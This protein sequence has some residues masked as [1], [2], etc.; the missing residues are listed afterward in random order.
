MKDKPPT[1]PILKG[2]YVAFGHSFMEDMKCEG[3]GI[4]WKVHQLHG[5]ACPEPPHEHRRRGKKSRKR[6]RR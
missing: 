4:R 1:A 3:C 5:R 6:R 2:D